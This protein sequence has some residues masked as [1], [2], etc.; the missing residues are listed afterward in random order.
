M[1]CGAVLEVISLVYRLLDMTCNVSKRNEGD[2]LRVHRSELVESKKRQ[3]TFLLRLGARLYLVEVSQEF[4][5]NLVANGKSHVSCNFFFF[6]FL[7]FPYHLFYSFF[8]CFSPQLPSLP[9]C[10]YFCLAV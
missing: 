10:T 1:C 7:L 5:R 3:Q 4:F 9:S 8:P 6:F 2:F